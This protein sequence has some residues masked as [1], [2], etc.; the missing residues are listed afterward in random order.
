MTSGVDRK[1]KVGQIKIYDCPAVKRLKMHTH[2][3]KHQ[4]RKDWKL[5]PDHLKSAVREI[6]DYLGH[7]TLLKLLP[8]I[9][10]FPGLDNN[11]NI[12]YQT[13]CDQYIS[14]K[15]GFFSSKYDLSAFWMHHVAWCNPANEKKIIVDTMNLFRKRRMKGYVCVPIWKHEKQKSYMHQEKYR[16]I[17]VAK[18]KCKTYCVLDGVAYGKNDWRLDV[19]VFYYD[20]QC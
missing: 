18:R 3:Q 13:I 6:S 9:D 4:A 10:C 20:Y 15:N 5:K 12:T 1:R 19:I 11:E 8:T 7:D 16:W 17:A 14:E 2:Q